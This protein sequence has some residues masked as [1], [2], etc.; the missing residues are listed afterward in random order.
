[1][2]KSKVQAKKARIIKRKPTPP[3]RKRQR[4][5][6]GEMDEDVYDEEGREMLVDEDEISPTEEAFL[7][8]YDAGE[9]VAKCAKCGKIL[10]EDFFEKE[11]SG[12]IYRFCSAEHAESFEP[13][14]E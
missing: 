10:F 3:E 2:A 14:I 4:I 9:K 13:E 5:E 11:I 7:E 1:M 12:E 6:R 8:G